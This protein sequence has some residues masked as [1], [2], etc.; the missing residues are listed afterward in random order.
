LDVLDQLARFEMTKALM[1]ELSDAVHPRGGGQKLKTHMDLSVIRR[2]LAT[3]KYDS[4]KAWKEDV[5]LIWFNAKNYSQT[6]GASAIVAKYLKSWFEKRVSRIP[7]SGAEDWLLK[8][9]R[10]QRKAKKLLDL[11][12]AKKTE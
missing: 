8:F 3:G 4:V 5:D 7:R 12:V 6:G 11:Q 9:K 10:A 2:K 1:S